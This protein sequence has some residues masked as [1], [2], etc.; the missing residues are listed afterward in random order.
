M[1]SSSLYSDIREEFLSTGKVL[2]SEK[3][4][5][6]MRGRVK[7]FGVQMERFLCKDRI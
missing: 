2:E 7:G 5:G 3:E 1:S 4:G 6:I